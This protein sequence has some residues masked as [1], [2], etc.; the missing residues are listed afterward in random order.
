M[1]NLDF[2]KNERSS[3]L[4]GFEE[5]VHRFYIVQ[6]TLKS[7]IRFTVFLIL[8]ILV[9]ATVHFSVSRIGPKLS[10]SNSNGVI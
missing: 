8:S 10:T 7:G 9:A 5:T 3:K 1:Q 4:S 6:E 2:L